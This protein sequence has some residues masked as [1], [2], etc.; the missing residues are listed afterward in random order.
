MAKLMVS[1]FTDTQTAI[2]GMSTMITQT[3]N[4]YMASGMITINA[5]Q[6]Q[7][8]GIMAVYETEMNGLIAQS[9]GA[10]SDLNNAY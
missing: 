10:Y 4:E 1:G 7:I 2:N 8:S 6:D 3:V 5:S 9:M